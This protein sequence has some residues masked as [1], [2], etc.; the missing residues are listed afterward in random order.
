MP[1]GTERIVQGW[2][3][4]LDQEKFDGWMA[5]KISVKELVVR[6]L[7]QYKLLAKSSKWA[8]LRWLDGLSGKGIY[9]WLHEQRGDLHLGEERKTVE[10]IEADLL[11]VRKLVEAL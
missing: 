7:D 10:R 5:G 4:Q 6:L 1:A 9:D 3:R 8:I 2:L 11:E